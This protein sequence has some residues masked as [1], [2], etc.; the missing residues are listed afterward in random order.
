MRRN[1][2][3]VCVPNAS[4]H[5]AI[6]VMMLSAE[7]FCQPHAE[8]IAETGLLVLSRVRILRSAKNDLNNLSDNTAPYGLDA[9]LAT[10]TCRKLF[11]YILR[12]AIS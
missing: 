2:C 9:I 6:L 11:R 12:R 5:L 3:L 10:H 8:V 7:A 1:S 4:L